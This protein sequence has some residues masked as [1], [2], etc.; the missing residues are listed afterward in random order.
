[1]SFVD[2]M[3]YGSAN[4]SIDGYS[5]DMWLDEE[6]GYWDDESWEDTDFWSYLDDLIGGGLS[7]YR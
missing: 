7:F 1:M 2:K 5:D 6:N 3:A 4:G